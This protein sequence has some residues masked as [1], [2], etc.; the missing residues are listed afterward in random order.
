MPVRAWELG[1]FIPASPKGSGALAREGAWPSRGARGRALLLRFALGCSHSFQERIVETATF[2]TPVSQP[3][4]AEAGAVGDVRWNLPGPLRAGDPLNPPVQAG[5]RHCSGDG[6]LTYL[7]AGFCSAWYPDV[8]PDFWHSSAPD[9]S[10]LFWKSSRFVPV[11]REPSF[12]ENLPMTCWALS[13]SPAAV[14]PQG[15][16]W[17]QVLCAGTQVAWLEKQALGAQSM[18]F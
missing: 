13:G 4:R 6:A 1:M 10:L 15:V 7:R 17:G 3:G 9:F 18:P 5:G 12:P 16:V 11:S 14:L 8:S 2:A